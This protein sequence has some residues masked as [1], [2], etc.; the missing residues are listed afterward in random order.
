MLFF[1]RSEYIKP[2]FIEKREIAIIHPSFPEPEFIPQKIHRGFVNLEEMGLKVKEDPQI[3]NEYIDK[4]E[5]YKNRAQIINSSFADQNI[6]ALFCKTGGH[7]CIN[8]LKHLEDFT[9]KTNPKVVC[10]YSDNTALLLYLTDKLNMVSFHGLTLV[11]G[12]SDMGEIAQEYFKKIFLGNTY[13]IE[14]KLES[15]VA[16]KE[17]RTTGVVMGGNLTRLVEYLKE[18]PNT[19]FRNK[20]LFIEDK[21]ETA[22]DIKKMLDFLKEKGIFRDIKGILIGFFFGNEVREDDLSVVKQHLLTTLGWKRMPILYGFMSGHCTE[23][24]VLP[25]GTDITIEATDSPKV[26]YKECPFK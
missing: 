23:K 16:W 21:G 13:P 10:G 19:N 6:G 26:I 11:P 20:I 4:E 14:I 24:I 7:G 25:F 5:G 22:E 17:G 18:Y 12:V 9:I 2:A 1:G 3:Y 8:V 15:L